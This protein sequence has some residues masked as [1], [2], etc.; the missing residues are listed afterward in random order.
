MTTVTLPILLP[1]K[2]LMA[3]V[4]ASRAPRLQVMEKAMVSSGVLTLVLADPLGRRLPA[5]APGAHI[6]LALDTG[7][8]RQ[9]SLCGDRFD[10][11]R[12]RV[13]VLREKDGRGGSAYIHDVLRVGDMV[14]L[15]GP[16][17]NFPLV[18]ADRLTF[19]AGGIGITP[20]LPMLRQADALG[21]EW[22][23]LY[24][25]R[26]RHS[27]GFLDELAP[28]GNR[29]TVCPEDES[30]QLDLAGYLRPVLKQ[31]AAA[32]STGGKN[33]RHP[34]NKVYACGPTGLLDAVDALCADLP[35]GLLRTERFVSTSDATVRNERFDLELA[36]SGRVLTVDSDASVLDVLGRNGVTVVS[37]CQ[38][39]VCGTCEVPVLS[40][41]VD[42]RDSL[43]DED[44]RAAS[45]C[46]FVCVSR[47]LD[48]RLVL[49][50]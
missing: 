16:R 37:S 30:G 49:D 15:G 48:D 24:G 14:G 29:V 45:D 1:V 18:P 46:M 28:Y 38:Q 44:E 47:A 7:Y 40:G 3:S 19:V 20:L 12:Y 25:G 50:L 31:S 34:D 39:G 27:M 11:F 6:D 17:N 32:G 9:Y 5:W 42:H 21:I 33:S 23:L 43:L 26:T 4:D 41:M 2:E 10:P 36:R 13:G 35:D 8:T 22:S